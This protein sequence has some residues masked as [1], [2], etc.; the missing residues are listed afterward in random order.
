MK[1]IR[2]LVLF[3]MLSTLVNAQ[4]LNFQWAKALGEGT[5][6]ISRSTAVDASGNVYITGQF[7]GTS[8][9]DPG[10]GVYNLTSSTYDI[11]VCKLNSSGNFLWTKSFGSSGNNDV[12]FE[13]AAGSSG[14]YVTGIF[15]DTADFDPGAGVFKLNS[16]GGDD[17]FILKLSA[18]GNF[19]WARSIGGPNTDQGNS[20]S[21]NSGGD[22]CITGWFRDSVDLDPGV[23]VAKAF[24]KGGDDIFMVKLDNAG[25][26]QWGNSFGGSGDDV[27][28]CVR[29]DQDDN[30]Y[31][32]GTLR[33][34]VDMDPGITDSVVHAAGG[35]DIF[36]SKFNS[37]GTFNWTRVC[38]SNVNEDAI[39]RKS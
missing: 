35:D 18:T 39:D 36:V 4:T 19:M 37:S 28:N 1:M 9:F 21:L 38:G 32:T 31:V 6:S 23:G 3:S 12:G 20:L 14:V 7:F 8:D 25:N 22:V 2:P 15:A 11:F 34:S 27:A 17:I 30:A 33:D 5:S 26:F 16:M 13:I 24:S 10:P 29:L